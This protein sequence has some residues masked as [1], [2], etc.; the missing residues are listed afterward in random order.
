MIALLIIICVKVLKYGKINL[1]YI[2][3]A[4][5]Q[6]HN[7]PYYERKLPPLPVAVSAF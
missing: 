4:D 6:N 2:H 3:L 7:T 5:L 1:S